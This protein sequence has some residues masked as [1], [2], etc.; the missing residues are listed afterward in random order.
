MSH[1]YQ[2]RKRAASLARAKH[3]TL[4][5]DCTPGTRTAGSLAGENLPSENR[6]SENRCCAVESVEPSV[7]EVELT[8]RTSCIG[9]SRQSAIS[10]RSR[11]LIRPN[12]QGCERCHRYGSP[13]RTKQ[14]TACDAYL[15]QSGTTVQVELVND[16]QQ[17]IYLGP[18]MPG[19]G[20]EQI[21]GADATGALLVPGF[22]QAT[23]QNV[24]QGT[25]PL[26]PPIACPV[27]STVTLQPGELT[28]VEWDGA[29]LRDASLPLACLPANAATDCPRIEGVTPGVYTF[30]AIA[31]T[32]LDCS[33]LGGAPCER[34]MP[35][36]AGGCWTPAAV[37]AGPFLTATSEVMLD[38]SYGV[39]DMAG[40]IARP[41]QVRFLS[42]AVRRT[43]TILRGRSLVQG[44]THARGA[45]A[46][47]EALGRATRHHTRGNVYGT[48]DFRAG[49]CRETGLAR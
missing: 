14:F 17:A 8:R 23:C 24:I 31:G 33:Q 10:A 18:Q 7:S 45:G 13:A 28:L 5:D 35:S 12:G 46:E 34:C 3:S 21:Q 15:D 29:F 11:S 27:N 37:I 32:K 48:D 30:S 2:S 22:C 47:S 1:S 38:G 4:S 41:V 9:S 43:M 25:T 36:S 6:S 26:C 44:S 20:G 16:T 42:H 39:G 49:S 19:C 40:G